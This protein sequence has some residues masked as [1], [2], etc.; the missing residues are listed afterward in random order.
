MA[1]DSVTKRA[2]N[3]VQEWIEEMARSES[4]LQFTT[5]H[6]SSGA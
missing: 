2:D 6:G 3:E 4:R 5:T 1:E